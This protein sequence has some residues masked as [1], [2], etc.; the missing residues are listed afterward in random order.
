MLAAITL[1]IAAL[2]CIAYGGWTVTA[3]RAIF[4]ELADGQA[5]SLDAAQESDRLHGV[6]LWTALA[7]LAV[8][9]VLWLLAH[10]L[11]RKPLGIVGFT[12]MALWVIGLLTALGGAYVT[13]L[14]DGD[15][16]AAGTGAVGFVIM[17]IGILLVAV[18]AIAAVIALFA[19]PARPETPVAGF[20]GWRPS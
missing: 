10:L 14:V 6:L 18:G 2:A 5:V 1:P 11:R 15:V 9:A 19:R 12:A 20:A 13:S 3:R 8:S 17:G 7:A 16:A 4:A